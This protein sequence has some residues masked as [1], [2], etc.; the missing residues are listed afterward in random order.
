MCGIA[1][2]SVA[3]GVEARVRALAIAPAAVSRA[4]S[5]PLQSPNGTVWLVSVDDAG[6]LSTSR[7]GQGV[8]R[9]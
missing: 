1:G 5:F 4:T 2:L 6:V 7:K 3:P 8:R 9:V